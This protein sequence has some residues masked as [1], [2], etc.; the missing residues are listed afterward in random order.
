MSGIDVVATVAACRKLLDDVL[1]GSDYLGAL[2]LFNCKG[3]VAF[4][5][6]EFGVERDVYVGM[7]LK[8]VK[9]DPS[10]PLAISMRNV[11]EG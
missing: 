6:K 11:I 4:V 2:R 9:Q 5:A 7:V 3:V 8:L 1:S 10:G